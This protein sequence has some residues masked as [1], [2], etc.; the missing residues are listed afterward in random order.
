MKI[1]MISGAK[2][3]VS[4]GEI[5]H[6]LEMA[7]GLA[8]AGARVTLALRGKYRGP[9]RQGVNVVGLPVMKNKYLDGLLRPVLVC[10]A[11]LFL[12]LR[13]GYDAVY[14]RDSIYEMPVV[15]LLKLLGQFTLLELNTVS[16]EDLRAKG[17]T[18]WKQAVAGWAQRK[19]CF[20]A[21]L[22]L[23]V[24]SSLAGWLAGQGVP[25]EKVTVVANGANPYLYRPVEQKDALARLGL[26]PFKQYLCFAGNLAAWQGG[27]IVVEAFDRIAGLCRDAMLLIIGDGPEREALEVQVRSKGL[28]GR[29]LFTGRVPYNRVPIYLSACVAGIG[30]GW[31]GENMTLKRRFC[32]SGSSA[33]K[34]Y[35]YLACS[36]PVVVPDIADLSDIVR[37][38]GCGLVVEPDRV[39]SLA[40]A[41]TAMLEY[42]LAWAEAGRRGRYFIE[43]EA[44][45]EHR[46][47]RI[48]SLV[49]RTRRRKGRW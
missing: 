6:T 4:T 49:N 18:R 43:K 41:L 3:G 14:I 45:W 35:S 21:A 26:D 5:I 34:F 16:S 32:R 1:L 36:L 28:A 11:A 15:W 46:A 22:V 42:P 33:L 8:G 44:A 10:M 29:V 30:G 17:R 13:V 25:A 23:P 37:L 2:A 40:A 12:I 48:I 24:T 31:Y 19:A 20:S 9:G 7:G 39:G 38:T 27:G 47:S